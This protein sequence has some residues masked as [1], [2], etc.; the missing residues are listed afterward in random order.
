MPVEE[1]GMFGFCPGNMPGWL[2]GWLDGWFPAEV[3]KLCSGLELVAVL[4]ELGIE[5]GTVVSVLL[6]EASEESAFFS[7]A[8]AVL[9]LDSFGD[10]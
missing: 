5:L 3:N 4:E 9:P 7:A 6:G 10:C 8:A 2:G 1:G